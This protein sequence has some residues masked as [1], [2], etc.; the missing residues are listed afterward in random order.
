VAPETLVGS[1]HSELEDAIEIWTAAIAPYGCPTPF[2]IEP[3]DP[4]AHD[5]AL[6]PR[7]AWTYDPGASGVAYG[8]TPW[9]RGYIVV[10]YSASYDYRQLVLVHEL[11]HALGLGDN[12][13]VSSVM[14]DANI[15][16][17]PSTAD[18]LGV[19]NGIGCI[20]DGWR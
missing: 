7:E 11:G 4:D 16:T 18:A 1:W 13:D 6:I 2:R 20:G 3:D 8:D 5:V 9:E 15:V 19:A 10:K 17:I 14:H 12:D